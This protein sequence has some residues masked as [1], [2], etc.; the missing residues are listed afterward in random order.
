MRRNRIYCSLC[1]LYC[2]SAC[3]AFCKDFSRPVARP[4]S[5]YPAHDD[6]TAEKVCVAADPYD[7]PGKGRVFSVDFSEKGFLP[8]FFVVTNNGDRAISFASLNVQLITSHHSKLSPVAPDDIY[9]RMANPQARTTPSPIPIPRKKIKGA[10]TQKEM[11]EIES[12]QFAARA[13]EPHST[14]SGFLFFD[15]A[16]ISNP[17]SGADLDVTG[18]F[19]ADGKEFLYFEISMEKSSSAPQVDR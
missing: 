1:L 3:S 2:F 12:S 15:I 4:C 9:R 5:T 6:H 14:Q 8:V 7:S 10:I 19:D 17:V 16:G 11:D 13:V 18:I